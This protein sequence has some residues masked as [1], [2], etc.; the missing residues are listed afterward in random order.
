MNIDLAKT[1]LGYIITEKVV[2]S[3]NTGG[4]R[5]MRVLLNNESESRPRD[6]ILPTRGDLGIHLDTVMIIHYVYP[7]YQYFPPT[8]SFPNSHIPVLISPR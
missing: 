4:I 5:S 2:Y 8:L 7:I 6:N 3:E 1:F